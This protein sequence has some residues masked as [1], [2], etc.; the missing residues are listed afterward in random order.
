MEVLKKSYESFIFAVEEKAADLI[1]LST[2]TSKKKK[3]K[4]ELEKSYKKQ[5]FWTKKEKP[6]IKLLNKIGLGGKKKKW[7][8]L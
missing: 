5:E 1:E 3:E 8:L 7:K 4:S 2:Q 6:G